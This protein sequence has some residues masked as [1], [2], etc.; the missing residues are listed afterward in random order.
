MVAG[1]E[2]G[3]QYTGL[4]SPHYSKR[5]SPPQLSSRTT[6]LAL[7]EH[8]PGA[9]A[10]RPAAVS[11]GEY[12]HSFHRTVSAAPQASCPVCTSTSETGRAAP[13]RPIGSEWVSW[14]YLE[15]G[16]LAIGRAGC[17]SDQGHNTGPGATP[18]VCH[19]SHTTVWK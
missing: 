12:Q 16:V 9:G 8:G 18:G 3:T 1:L 19:H 11:A 2:V 17:P 7:R 14:R 5:T 6:N 4:S 13:R 15:W 10:G